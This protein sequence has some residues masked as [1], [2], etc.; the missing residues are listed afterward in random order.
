MAGSETKPRR[1]RDVDPSVGEAPLEG[2]SVVESAVA[3]NVQA[4]A[5]E[6]Q[7]RRHQRK[8]QAVR[9]DGEAA[10]ST[11]ELE[12]DPVGEA[13]LVVES[14]GEALVVVEAVAQSAVAT[15]E[16]A[17]EAIGAKVAA[18]VAALVEAQ[19]PAVSLVPAHS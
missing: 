14:V 7:G 3:S 15:V 18:L 9:S 1:T 17:V 2:E 19:R 8:V 12:V 4:S 5:A 16:S 13:L 6:I 11:A 10:A